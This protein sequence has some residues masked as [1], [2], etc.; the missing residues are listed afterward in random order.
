MDKPYC[1]RCKHK[2][3]FNGSIGE[4]LCGDGKHLN[5]AGDWLYPRC[6]LKNKNI[7]PS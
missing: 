7:R 4:K 3:A 2:Q 5:Y 6:L 1:N